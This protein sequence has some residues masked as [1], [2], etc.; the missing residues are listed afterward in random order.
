MHV[1]HETATEVPA[2]QPREPLQG[3]TEG[4]ISFE[5]FGLNRQPDLGISLYHDL[6]PGMPPHETMLVPFQRVV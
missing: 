1:P 5:R 3:L 2:H 4:R 6:E